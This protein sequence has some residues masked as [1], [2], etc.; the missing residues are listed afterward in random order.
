MSQEYESVIHSVTL[1]INL[2]FYKGYIKKKG[3]LFSENKNIER[4]S[5]Q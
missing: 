2:T 5:E 3:R 1:E 4:L